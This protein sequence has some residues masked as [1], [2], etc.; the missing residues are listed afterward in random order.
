MS[1]THGFVAQNSFDRIERG[2]MIPRGRWAMANA[3]HARESLQAGEDHKGLA[4]P[5]GPG[6]ER[7]ATAR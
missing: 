1:A 5:K 6:D 2:G 3:K 7:R 4:M